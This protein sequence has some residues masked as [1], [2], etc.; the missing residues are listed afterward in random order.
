MEDQAREQPMLETAA[1]YQA[2]VD[3]CLEQMRRLRTQ[4][5]QEQA[6]IERLKSET[7]AILA[8][9]KAA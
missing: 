9:L 6:V 3:R 8:E 5:E 4:M 1:D 7:R 2:A